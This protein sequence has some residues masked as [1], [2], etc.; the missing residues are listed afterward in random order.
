MWVLRGGQTAFVR[1]DSVRPSIERTIRSHLAAIAATNDAEIARLGRELYDELIA[2]ASPH[3]RGVRNLVIIGDG[4]LQTVPFAAL[5]GPDHRYL[6]QNFRLA[7]APSASVFARN[8]RTVTGGREL[9]AVAQPGP[10]GM[11]FLPNAEM[12]VRE[13]ADLYG[14]DHVLVGSEVDPN[15]FLM[16]SG[17]A[18]AVHF[19]GHAVLDDHQPSASSLVF[20][21][22]QNRAPLLLR[23]ETIAATRLPSRPLVVL[24]GCSTGRGP[25]RQNEGVD[26]LSAAFLRAGARGVVATLWDIDDSASSR[27]LTTFHR[28]LG[29]GATASDALRDAQLSLI[30]SS[31]P[32]DRRPEAWAGF[33]LLGTM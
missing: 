17:R 13:V 16:R 19:A 33:V 26:S 29:S 23:A 1:G 22:S 30:G 15:N 11:K 27:L 14:N 2:P 20:E 12:E 28:H 31:D 25:L 10:S 9:L 7:F 18:S 21:S 8:E 24:A 5:V 32:N 6:I 4:A 3:L